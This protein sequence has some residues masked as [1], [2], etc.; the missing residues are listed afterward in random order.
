MQDMCRG[1]RCA[2]LT[3]LAVVVTTALPALAQDGFRGPT[4]DGVRQNDPQTYR[5]QGPSLSESTAILESAVRTMYMRI[6]PGNDTSPN[7]LLVYADL[8]ALRLYTGALEVA[9]WSLEQSQADFYRYQTAG[10]YRNGYSRV[11]DQKAEMALARYRAYRESCRTLLYRVRTTAVSVE[12]QVAVCAP[13]VA[14]EWRDQVLPAL[15][16][17]ISSTEPMFEEQ[18][19]YSGY[20]VPGGKTVAVGKVQLTSNGVPEGACDVSRNLTYKPYNGEGR[21]MGRYVEV[22]AYGGAVHVTAVRFRSHER[23]VGAFDTSVIREVSVDQ[24]AEPGRPLYI[25][26]N[27][28]RT[29]DLSDLE[30]VWDSHERN[31]RS[32]ATV[33]LVEANPNDRN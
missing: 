17:L 26:A 18:I 29:V 21:G 28:G 3:S 12:H 16:D 9:G 7:E 25:P 10:A 22:R 24:I 1:R 5:R 4:Q 19:V 8:R 33:E 15:R 11:Q 31:R 23:A 30:I 32:Y 20:G 13:E 6:E 2:W 27:R 14:H